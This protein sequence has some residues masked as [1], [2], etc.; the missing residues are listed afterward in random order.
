MLTKRS[1]IGSELR[2]IPEPRLGNVELPAILICEGD[3][4]LS[5]HALSWLAIIF[6]S[7]AIIIVICFKVYTKDWEIALEAG[8]FFFAGVMVIVGLEQ[9]FQSKRPRS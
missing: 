6:I 4:V 3:D 8:G 1:Q 9:L 2:K 7:L 5:R